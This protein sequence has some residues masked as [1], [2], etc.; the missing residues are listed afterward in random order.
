[1][2]GW[3]G[4]GDGGV[5]RLVGSGGQLSNNKGWLYTFIGKWLEV[6]RYRALVTL[7]ES[8]LGVG[9]NDFVPSSMKVVVKVAVAY[10]E[11]VLQNNKILKK[12]RIEVRNT[13]NVEDLI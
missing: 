10:T 2:L 4:R 3:W 7:Q 6:P 12:R 11:N 5:A 1:M 9:L 13:F 8:L